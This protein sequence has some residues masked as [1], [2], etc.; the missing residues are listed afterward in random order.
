M[1]TPLDNSVPSS[2]EDPLKKLASL[3]PEELTLLGQQLNASPEAKQEFKE[4]LG[5]FKPSAQREQSKIDSHWNLSYY[6]EVY[7]RELLPILD[8]MMV[9]GADKEFLIR[10][11]K[12]MKVGTL[13]T[14]VTHS[15]MFVCEQLDPT[16]KYKE[17]RKKFEIS[18]TVK[19]V[20]L[21]RIDVAMETLVATDVQYE[22]SFEEV[23]E[24]VM[25]AIEQMP[26]Q[27]EITF[28]VKGMEPFELSDPEIEVL[29]MKAGGFPYITMVAS[30]DIIKIVKTSPDGR[31]Q[32]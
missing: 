9:D 11:F 20:R 26:F 25:E 14:R 32:Q 15:I 8:K 31:T 18:K 28:P 10:N 3:S 16:G 7:G 6:R 17:F 4:K 24:A 19:S 30:R 27:S 29:N 23:M 22:T 2:P 5:I 21:C 12:W 13:H 1:S